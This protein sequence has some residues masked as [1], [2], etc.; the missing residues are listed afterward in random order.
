MPVLLCEL[1]VKRYFGGPGR[2]GW[3]W[4]CMRQL[5]ITGLAEL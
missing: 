3:T 2:P 5:C 4:S 1:V